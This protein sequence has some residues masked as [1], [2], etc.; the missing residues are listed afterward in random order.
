MVFT[1]SRRRS[2]EGKTLVL[3]KDKIMF[4]LYRKR[5]VAGKGLFIKYFILYEGGGWLSK[6]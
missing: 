4:T 1:L 6:K 5:S 3:C 2:R